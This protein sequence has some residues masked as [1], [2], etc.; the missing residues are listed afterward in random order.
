[1]MAH[2]K[3]MYSL[4]YPI[5]IF[6]AGMFTD[7]LRFKYIYIYIQIQIHCVTNVVHRSSPDLKKK[8][9]D[10]IITV[11]MKQEQG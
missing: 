10:I 7:T 8:Y 9:G 11:P 1:M 2:N 6:H 4:T 5:K 3:W